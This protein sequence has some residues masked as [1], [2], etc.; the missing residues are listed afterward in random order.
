MAEP[1][2]DVGLF[3]ELLWVHGMLRR[4]L[5]LCLELAARLEAGAPVTDARETVGELQT[6]GLLWTL[7][8]RCLGYCTFVHHH[9]GAEDALVFP[10]VRAT[11][12]ERYS[13]VVDKLMADHQVVA[14]LLDEVEVAAHGL[15]VDV[16]ADP[17]VLRVRLVKGLTDLSDHLLEH[18]A[19]E[20]DALGP[21]LRSWTRWPGWG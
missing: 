13:A 1:G 2:S 18:L 9:H 19:Y 16:S 10:A 21:V 17:E 7:R 3:G 14:V 4:D 6:S 8:T 20:E 15:D 12:P 11:D 5:A